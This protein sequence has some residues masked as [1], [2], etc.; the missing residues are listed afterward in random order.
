MTT[1]WPRT[2]ELEGSIRDAPVGASLVGDIDFDAPLTVTVHFQRRSPPPPPL[3]SAKDIERLSKR[4]TREQLAKQRRKT[5]RRA[6]ARI[7]AFAKSQGIVVA[8]VDY[9]ARSMTLQAPARVLAKAFYANLRLYR[10]DEQVF[11]ART[12]ALHIPKDIAPWTRA[13]IGFDQRPLLR[14]ATVAAPAGPD[15][16]WP[17][18]IA[19]LYGIP[20]DQDMSA[21]C[22]GV[23]AL[24]G[25]YQ[26][27]DLAA[28]LAKMGRRPPIVVDQS[29]G[30][31]TNQFSGGSRYDM[32]IAL[33]LQ[34]VASFVEGGRV[35]VY[36]TSNSAEG[37]AA[38]IDQA[39]RDGTNKPQVLSLSWGGPEVYWTKPRRDVVMG[40]LSDAVR[41]GVSVVTASGDS[42]ATCGL[43]DGKAHVW[44]P[45]SAPYALGCGGTSVSLTNAG[46]ISENV[47]N[48]GTAGTGGGISDCDEF[49]VPAFQSA[50]NLPRSVNDGQIRRGVPDV[51][52]MAAKAPGYRIVVNRDE[53]ALDGTSAATPL[54][55]GLIAMANAK[56][57]APIGLVN[58][59]LYATPQLMR[60]IT[61]G[62]NQQNGLG[63]AATAG[64][65]A[66]TGLGAPLGA[67]LLAVLAAMREA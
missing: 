29:V 44:F 42:L 18:Q 30:G 12:G 11:R 36:F 54:W 47:W 1:Q 67:Q 2:V 4:M 43:Q 51:A 20:L 35:V 62:D 53:W 59:A 34:V 28:A 22:V 19:A 61:V 65:S 10:D 21:Q 13:V 45:A 50:A 63:Y 58:P 5:H 7:E 9:G 39:I 48:D 32:E 55:A 33:D 17:S 37:L 6:A 15:S 24:G 38:A 64:W 66:C 56:R 31:V 46:I 25:G 49:P 3:G 60:P 16:M 57:G 23:I 26:P 8:A 14:R 41:L 27:E 40:S 52:A